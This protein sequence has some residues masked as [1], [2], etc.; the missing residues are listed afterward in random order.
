M[1]RAKKIRKESWLILITVCVLLLA[2]IIIYTTPLKGKIIAAWSGGP[3]ANPSDTPPAGQKEPEPA[4]QPQPDPGEAPV[5]GDETQPDPPKAA[6]PGN[7]TQPEPGPK[8]QAPTIY[9]GQK[10]IIPQ[11]A[12]STRDK[13]QLIR[14]GVTEVA[15]KQIALTF[16]AGW[17]YEQTEDLLAVLA[18]YE[19]KSTFFARAR[20]VEAHPELAQEIVRHG[21]LLENHSLTHGHL[22]NMS[23]EEMIAEMRESTRIITEATGRTPYLFRPPYGEYNDTL[24]NVLA[25]EGYPYTIMWTVDSH[26]WAEEIG[27]RKVTTEYLIDRVLDNA[28]HKGIIL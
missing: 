28:S 17:L 5:P 21:H 3:G 26:D 24:L 27:G 25:G 7:E 18:E 14:E 10:L 16:D 6:Q 4:E 19:V 12:G 22:I 15:E 20:W 2:G 1:L 8:E 23:K 13:S 9:A 11:A